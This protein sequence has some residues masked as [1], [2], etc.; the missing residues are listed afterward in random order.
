MIEIRMSR[1]YSAWIDDEDEELVRQYKW[2]P[3]VQ[4][5]TTYAIARLPRKNG[6][7]RSMYM[8]RLITHAKPGERVLHTDRDGLNNTRQNLHVQVARGAPPRHSASSPAAD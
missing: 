7:Q 6:K 1:G 5:H 2:R 4:G 3:L 8:H